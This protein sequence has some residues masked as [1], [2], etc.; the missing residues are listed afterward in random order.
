MLFLSLARAGQGIGGAVMFATAL[1]LLSSAFSGKERGTAFAF[2]G[3]TTGVAVAI[4]PVLGGVLTSGLSWNWIF[5]VNI[6]ICVF[7]LA[8]TLTKVEENRDPHPGRLDLV[9][10]LTFSSGLGLLV[11]ALIRGGVDG[12]GDSP[13]RRQLR[14]QRAC[15]WCRSW[16]AR[17]LQESADVRPRA[18]PQADLRRRPGRRASGCRRRCS[19]C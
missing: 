3:A 2:F 5:F 11:L 7:A 9:G 12:W 4:G 6:P 13:G 10:F 17:S 19:R 14:G 8:V 18:A 1:A 16:S 15:C